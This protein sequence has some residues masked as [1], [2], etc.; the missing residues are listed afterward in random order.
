MEKSAT[1]HIHKP[2][3]S[4]SDTI[5]INTKT[6]VFYHADSVQLE[7]FRK[8]SSVNVY[9][10][11]VHESFFQMMTSRSELKKYW[12]KI[13][14][15][16]AMKIRYLAFQKKDNSITVID[17]NTNGNM[18]GLYLFDPRKEP[19]FADMMNAGTALSYYF[20]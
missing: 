11:T 8:I 1:T 19:E 20:K 16:E 4:Y 7:K 9:E 10:S 18:Y 3:S 14:I 17:L 2:P 13:K 6:A 5:L 15:I 12:P